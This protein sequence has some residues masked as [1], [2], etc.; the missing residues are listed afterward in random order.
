MKIYYLQ[1]FS[2]TKRITFSLLNLTVVTYVQKHIRGVPN[3]Q[4][5][6]NMDRVIII[7]RQYL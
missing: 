7:Y 6:I 3:N 4:L 2:L 5:E 1:I